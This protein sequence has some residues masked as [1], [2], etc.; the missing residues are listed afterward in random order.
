MRAYTRFVCESCGAEFG[1]RLECLMHER[2]CGDYP[3]VFGWDIGNIEKGNLVNY[4]IL[5]ALIL[6]F[7]FM[8]S[9]L[10]AETTGI[11]CVTP[12]SEYFSTIKSI[13]SRFVIH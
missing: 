6:A 7:G 8:F 2:V 11:K 3:A 1:E 10:L 12:N 13:Y 5:V 9:K 4:F